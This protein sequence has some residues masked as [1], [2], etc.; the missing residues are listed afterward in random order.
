VALFSRRFTLLAL[1]TATAVVGSLAIPATSMAASLATPSSLAPDNTGDDVNDA[2]TWQKDPVLSWS[3][4]TGASGYD[5]QLANSDDFTD[6]TNLWSLPSGGHVSGPSLALPQPLDHGA[7][8]WRVRAT[9]SAVNGAWS[10]P[11]ELYRGWDDAPTADT[12]PIGNDNRING[13]MPWRFSWSAIPD[14]SS[15]EIEFSVSPTFPSDPADPSAQS[16]KWNDGASTLDCLTTR[17][18]FTPYTSVGNAD[19]G[20]DT[21]DFSAFDPSFAPVFWRVR[22]VDDSQAGV[23]AG[24]QTQILDCFGAPATSSDASPD[25]SANTPSALGTPASPSHECSLW[26]ATNVVAYPVH[27]TGAD[28]TTF[29]P[30]SAT[31]TNCGA[32]TIAAT[33]SNPAT[34]TCTDTPEI[35]WSPVSDGGGLF[36]NTYMVTIADDP[37]FTNVERVFKTS[38]L[39][40][41]PRDDF[42]D[43]NA[44]RG[45][46]VD[47]AACGDGGGGCTSDQKL[48]FVK[49]T[50]RIAAVSAQH[51]NGAERFTWQDLL[52]KYPNA[53]SVGGSAAEADDYILQIADSSDTDFSSPVLNLTVD[54]SCDTALAITCYNPS[55][56]T[57]A[58]D[59][60][61]VV[62]V[63][64]GTYV[65]R[66]VPVDRA[67]NHLPASTPA[68]VSIDTTA[69]QLSLTTK[70]GIPVNSALTMKSSEAVTGVSS[71]S[72]ELVA[73]AGGAL[74]PVTVHL[75]AAAN[76]WTLIPTQKLVTG[77]RYAL[78]LITNGIH[79]AA[80]N[81]AVVGGSSVRTSTIADDRS[82]AWSWGSGWTRVASSNAIGGTFERGASG[83]AV[84]LAVAGSSISVY[85][86]KGPAYGSLVVRVDG[87]KRATVSEHQSFTKCGLLLWTGSVSTNAQ[88][89]LGLVTAG[90]ATVDEV[91]L[92]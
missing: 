83:H 80:G 92:A 38:K 6:S 55:G 71:S 8:W 87:V 47:V 59:A 21:C 15:Y 66:V 41:T 54:R 32:P 56:S 49:T 61:A 64:D 73:V 20:V 35:A 26:S 65:W 74:A 90:T 46:Y 67:G 50:P 44:G 78:H 1:S 2:S 42:R 25:P 11:A 60:Q 75:G 86:C 58:G 34:Y 62:H 4:V 88:H 77:Q 76:T 81:T 85:G 17:T 40:L 31:I 29:G 91:K 33:G 28:P 53:G 82:V 63:A 37:G 79:D 30:I 51:L 18:T 45:Y 24:P 10:A 23:P 89:V 84:S 14:A 13:T 5:V 22:G 9:T 70:S 36:T 43:Y 48:T 39:S 57:A 52:G 3:A 12:N 7:Y 16:A 27:D 19:Q 72:V 68:A 69:P